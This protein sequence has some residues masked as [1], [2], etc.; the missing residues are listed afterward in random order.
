MMD[1]DVQYIE[2]RKTH[3]LLTLNCC[4]LENTKEGVAVDIGYR[5][6]CAECVLARQKH[7]CRVLG[8]CAIVLCKF[9]KSDAELCTSAGCIGQWF[10]IVGVFW[11]TGPR[12]NDCNQE[13]CFADP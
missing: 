7:Q 11:R 10:D 6:V 1:S 13:C 5:N 9:R 3:I 2:E 4:I 8:R 12:H